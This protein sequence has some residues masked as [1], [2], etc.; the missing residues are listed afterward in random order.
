MKQLI[1]EYQK[2]LS[3]EST[4]NIAPELSNM[5]TKHDE[6]EVMQDQIETGQFSPIKQAD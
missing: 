6:I 1:L 5:W 2:T 3:N 4:N